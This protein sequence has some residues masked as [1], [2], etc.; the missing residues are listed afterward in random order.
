MQTLN[1]VH[2]FAE[3]G[4]QVVRYVQC[5]ADRAHCAFRVGRRATEGALPS[6]LRVQW[7]SG[8]LVD[9]LPVTL[10]MLLNV[11]CVLEGLPIKSLRM[12]FIFVH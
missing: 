9:V 2:R 8:Q 1:S 3:Q 10:Y 11:F 7:P 6:R 5:Y 4:L 12:P